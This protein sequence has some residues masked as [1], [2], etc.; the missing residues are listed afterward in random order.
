MEVAAV[1]SRFVLSVVFLVAGAAKAGRRSEFEQAIQAYGLVPGRL[2]RPVAWTLPRAELAAG[3]LLALGLLTAPAAIAVAAMLVA[4][5]VAVTVNL[6]RGRQI[7]CGCF[8]TVAPH[9]IGWLVV[10]RN[11]ALAGLALCVAAVSP[12]SL[13]LDA[14]VLGG[15]GELSSSTSFATLVASTAVVAAFAL[16]AATRRYRELA[17]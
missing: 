3:S 12:R 2:V 17:R 16:A 4:F 7:D 1:A 14:V 8:S 11:L 9:R 15:A 13:S 10:A 5:S 6:A